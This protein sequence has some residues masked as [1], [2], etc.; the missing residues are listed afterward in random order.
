METPAPSCEC[1][2][3]LL[4]LRQYVLKQLCDLYR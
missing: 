1:V 4:V 2:S 3:D